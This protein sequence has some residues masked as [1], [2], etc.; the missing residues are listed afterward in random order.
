MF[1]EM[2]LTVPRLKHQ[3]HLP[4]EVFVSKISAFF[5]QALQF[6]VGW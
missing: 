2:F 3:L 6:T 4:V 1:I 5:H